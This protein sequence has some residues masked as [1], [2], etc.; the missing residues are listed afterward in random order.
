MYNIISRLKNKGIKADL[1]S[2][3]IESKQIEFE[4]N[5]FKGILD[6]SIKGYGLRLIHNN[7]EGFSYSNKLDEEIIDRAVDISK[8]GETVYYEFPYCN[9]NSENIFFDSKIEKIDSRHFID[10]AKEVISDLT[11]SFKDFYFSIKYNF[12]SKD[13]SLINTSGFDVSYSKTIFSLS[14]SGSS[15]NDGMIEV[16]EY[17]SS[18]FLDNLE[19]IFDR[20]KEKIVFSLKKASITSGEYEL[21]MT[22][23]ALESFVDILLTGFNGKL[24]EKGVSPLIELTG[25]KKGVDF[26]TII[27]NGT[28]KF[29]TGSFPFDGDGIVSNDKYLIENGVFGEGIFDLKTASRLNKKPTGN[30][31]RTYNSIPSIGFR[32]IIFVNGNKSINSI[33]KGIKKGVLVDQLLGA[34]MSNVLAGEFSANVDLGFLIENGE[35]VGRIK[36][37]MITANVFDAISR[38]LEVSKE[39][40]NF[41][42]FV[43]PYVLFDKFKVIS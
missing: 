26:L 21:I 32:N 30:S 41:G 7:R 36:D 25:K 20:L 23:K 31:I 1:F 24:I 42:S 8:F 2:E 39:T 37:T 6:K 27:D 43:G 29:L 19:C 13:V 28:D 10:F 11:K 16:Y 12:I 17:T 15:V 3:K 14:V 35:I 18:S 33:I 9:I 40:Y 4:N 22:P 34:G 5:K 38:I